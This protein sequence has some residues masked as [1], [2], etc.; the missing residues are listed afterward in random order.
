MR[1]VART[2]RNNVVFALPAAIEFVRTDDSRAYKM[3]TIDDEMSVANDIHERAVDIICPFH[4]DRHL[5][6]DVSCSFTRKT[7]VS[8]AI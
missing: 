6:I 4:L 5:T 2:H 3:L 8:F 1:D 7:S